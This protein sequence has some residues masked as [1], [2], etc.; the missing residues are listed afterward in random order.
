MDGLEALVTPVG[1]TMTGFN[2]GQETARKYEEQQNQQGLRQAQMQEILQNIEQRKQTNPLEVQSKQIKLQ[3]D[4]LDS[5][6]KQNEAYLDFLG[7][8]GTV[9][10]SVPSLP[11]Q[12]HAVLNQ[13]LAGS[14][15][16]GNNPEVQQVMKQLEQVPADQLPKTLG[17]LRDRLVQTSSAYQQKKMEMDAHLKQT[18]MTTDAS[19]YATDQRANAAAAKSKGIA[20]IQDQVRSGKMTAEK[21]AVALFGAAQFEQ[22]PVAKQQY[23]DMAKQYEQFAM[24]QRNASA[25]GRVDVGAA[26]NLPT[27]TLPPALG[28]PGAGPAPTANPNRRPLSQY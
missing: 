20:T 10:E 7:K 8:A 9:L 3:S 12:R 5:A 16:D 22:D 2:T 4:K 15:I 6:I 26:A 17:V 19:R 28:G 11:G 21:A 13:M 18:Q 27:Q 23:E 14:G 25:A 1:P 24:N